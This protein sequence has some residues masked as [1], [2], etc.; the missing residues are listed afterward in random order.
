MTAALLFLLFLGLMALG[1]A[2]SWCLYRAERWV[3]KEDDAIVDPMRDC[4]EENE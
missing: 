4:D 1:F 3:F 2:V